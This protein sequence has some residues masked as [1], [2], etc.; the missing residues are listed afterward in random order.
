MVQLDIFFDCVNGSIE[1]LDRI[2]VQKQLPG[3]V[4]VA[5]VGKRAASLTEGEIGCG[6]LAD[7][8]EEIVFL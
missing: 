3:I 1:D 4:Q 7:C 2:P 6:I 5:G 8:F